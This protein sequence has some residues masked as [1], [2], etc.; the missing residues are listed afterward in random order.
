[1]TVRVFLP[2][3]RP[4]VPVNAPL[5]EAADLP[6]ICPLAFGGCTVP[7]TSTL[8]AAIPA[9]RVGDVTATTTPPPPCVIVVVP[10]PPQPDKAIATAPITPT[11]ASLMVAPQR[12]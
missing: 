8:S 12:R 5:P 11:L 1:M 2:T 7:L 6:S 4:P 3:G 9:P 10:P